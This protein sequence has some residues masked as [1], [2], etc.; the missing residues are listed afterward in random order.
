M[1]FLAERYDEAGLHDLDLAIE[2]SPMWRYVIRIRIVNL[3]T[4]FYNVGDV[5]VRHAVF[6]EQG[7][8]QIVGWAT[9][10]ACGWPLG[11]EHYWPCPE[12]AV[13]FFPRGKEP[14]VRNRR[15]NILAKR[16]ELLKFSW[17]AHCS[18]PAE[19]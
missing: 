8:E 2:D 13:N 3:T 18:Y 1:N 12:K 6:L 16:F 10:A 9:K 17:G 7:I 11:D 4:R 15:Q 14:W 5:T 19:A